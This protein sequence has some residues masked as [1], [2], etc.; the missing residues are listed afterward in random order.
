MLDHLF[1][2]TVGRCG[3]RSSQAFWSHAGQDDR[4][5]LRPAHRRPRLGDVGQPA[6]RRRPAAGQ[7]RYQPRLADLEPV[8]LAE[9]EHGRAGR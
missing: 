1:L 4:L 7:R 8:G 9:Y 2:D 5:V 3:R 6:G